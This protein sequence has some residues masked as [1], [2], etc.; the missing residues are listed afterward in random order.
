[1]CN[2][3]MMHHPFALHCL[4]Q[5]AALSTAL[6]V[7]GS[8]V[9][10]EPLTPQ[11]TLEA[12]VQDF[13]LP[14]FRGRDFSLAELQDTKLIVLAFLGNECPL[15]KL[16]VHRLNQLAGE[17]SDDVRFLGINSNR[18]D[19]ITEL[20]A[21]A[22]RHEVDF[23]LLK[24]SANRIADRLHVFRTPEVIVLDRARRIRYRGR[25]DDQYGVGYA[26]SAPRREDLRRALEELAQ[27]TTVTQ[28]YLEP[29]GCLIGR[30]R[31]P[32]ATADVTYAKH[33]SSILHKH[34]VP[35]HRDGEIAPFSLTDYEEVV[36]WAE[37]IQEVVQQRR[38]PPW[39][40]NPDVGTFANARGMAQAEIALIDR[41]VEA[42]APAGN[43]ADLS[44]ADARSETSDGWRL[45]RPPDLELSMRTQPF[46]IP[47]TGTVEYQY[48]VVDPG[49]TEDKWISAAEVV[50]GNRAVV[51]HAIVFVRP[52]SGVGYDNVGWLSSYVPGQTGYAL[53]LGY[54]RRIPAGSR[55][56]FQMHYTPNGL[57]QTDNTKLG[58]VFTDA[59]QVTH[60]VSTMLAIQ[61]DFEIPPGAANHRVEAHLTHFPRGGQLLSVVPHMHVR[62]KSFRCVA[63]TED[64]QQTLLDVPA[65][66]FNW[67]H[68]YVFEKP[69]ELDHL[70]RLQ[71]SGTFDN[72]PNNLSNP[73]PTVSVRWGDQTWEEMLLGYFDVAVPRDGSQRV[74]V[75]HGRRGQP[76]PEDRIQARAKSWLDRFD[77]NK[78]GIVQ[79]HET[80]RAFRAFGFRHIDRNSD[81]SITLEE[82]RQAFSD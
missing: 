55:L 61:R 59:E 57:P 62:G 10:S 20:A 27:E 65:Y 34:C 60:E 36:G 76:I 31:E 70:H 71:C 17:F 37:M 11:E 48:F 49:F 38:M 19:S 9:S 32:A 80:P 53:P 77:K 47:A 82:A 73:D 43:L 63:H 42:G 66:D 8:S 28:P 22:R 40:A 14:D 13:T 15:A 1:M 45:P 39:G 64:A 46:A 56:V 81:A 4:R 5:I 25:I 74:Y 26:R 44:V 12:E 7:T 24:D 78:D 29:V 69:I 30:V 58:L 51:H 6:I 41:W 16:Y 79:R 35:C 50:A 3:S 54:A 23:P 21:F 33:V 72:S 2:K 67:Q 68:V 52:P 75:D 18:Q